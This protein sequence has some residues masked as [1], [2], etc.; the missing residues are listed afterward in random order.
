MIKIGRIFF[1]PTDSSM[2]EPNPLD[3]TNEVPTTALMQRQYIRWLVDENYGFCRSLHSRTFWLLDQI[4][5]NMET[6]PEM[7]EFLHWSRDDIE[8][9]RWNRLFRDWPAEL[10]LT[11]GPPPSANLLEFATKL[12]QFFAALELFDDPPP[13]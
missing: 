9:P 11:M 13:M 6:D 3:A 7:V 8:D 12:A 1:F 4:N 2:S 10:V 5:E